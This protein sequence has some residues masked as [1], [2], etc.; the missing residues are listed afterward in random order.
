MASWTG[1]ALPEE[2]SPNFVLVEDISSTA[3]EDKVKEFFNF[4]GTIEGF[5]LRPSLTGKA[6]E[7]LIRFEKDSAAK[8]AVLLSNA[9]IEEQPIEVK[10]YYS[11]FNT[12]DSPAAPKDTKAADPED[13]RSIGEAAEL[14]KNQDMPQE[15]KP[16]TSIIH[17]IL[18]KGYL[19]S[20]RIVGKAHEY[21]SK[22]GLTEKAQTM[23]NQAKQGALALDQRLKV[24]EN[25]KQIDEKYKLHDKVTNLTTQA[26]NLGNQALGTSAGQT[27]V[28]A[29]QQAKE[30]G[31]QTYQ[32]SVKLAEEMKRHEQPGVGTSAA[33]AVPEPSP[34]TQ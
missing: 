29:L 6:Q 9:M 28:N 33:A 34:S 27:I 18:A 5:A 15:D 3:T 2:P 20:E 11:E 17:E 24:S 14:L 10:Y 4:C 19:L 32:E 30:Q 1:M 8:T 22:Y 25:I 23:V 13:E 16:K 12:P 26:S 31:T 7:A 21:D